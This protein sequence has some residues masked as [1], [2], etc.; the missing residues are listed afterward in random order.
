MSSL[1]ERLARNLAKG[2][3]VERPEGSGVE[4]SFKGGQPV[5]LQ[6]TTVRSEHQCECN[7]PGP[8]QPVGKMGSRRPLYLYKHIF[9]TLASERQTSRAFSLCVRTLSADLGTPDRPGRASNFSQ[10]DAFC[11]LVHFQQLKQL[12]QI[13][14]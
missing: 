10:R 2:P 1:R 3:P 5:R 9:D 14:V 7:R 6:A 4:E 12:A 13:N 8:W 11:A